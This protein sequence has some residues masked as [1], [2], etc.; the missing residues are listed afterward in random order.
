MLS[1]VYW[2]H[3]DLLVTSLF[4]SP[5]FSHFLSLFKAKCLLS[6]PA[7]LVEIPSLLFEVPQGRLM[8]L[9]RERKSASVLPPV[10]PKDMLYLFL[11]PRQ[12]SV[13]KKRLGDLISRKGSVADLRTHSNLDPRFHPEVC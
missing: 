2:H 8:V 11:L 9:M 5:D 7:V 4:L 13:G 6:N 3:M 10:S 12:T 1:M